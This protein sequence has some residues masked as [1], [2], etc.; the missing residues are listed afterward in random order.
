MIP[1]VNQKGRCDPG[2]LRIAAEARLDR[3][4]PVDLMKRGI[5]CFHLENLR[6]ARTVHSQRPR[7]TQQARAF[8][9]A[10]VSSSWVAQVCSLCLATRRARDS[11][12]VRSSRH[13]KRSIPRRTVQIGQTAPTGEAGMRAHGSASPVIR[14]RRRVTTPATSYRYTFPTIT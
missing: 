1:R 4:Q 14:T 12:V 13:F 10:G 8:T 2:S 6:D 5:A 3:E 9:L 11:T 7:P